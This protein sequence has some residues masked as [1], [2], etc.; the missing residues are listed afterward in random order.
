MEENKGLSQIFVKIDENSK[1]EE[2]KSIQAGNLYVPAKEPIK[3][4]VVLYIGTDENG[5]DLKSFEVIE[6][7]LETFE[8][9]KG[10]VEYLDIHESKVLTGTV[11]YDKAI[12]VYDFMKYVS[13]IIEENSFDIED[14]NVGN[15]QRSE[16]SDEV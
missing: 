7:R 16:D 9:I 12:S 13:S 3:T 4:Y 2:M 14:Y 6:G 10:M 15:T 8:F 11:G 5:D 1:E